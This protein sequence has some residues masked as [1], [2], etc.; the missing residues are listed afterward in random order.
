MICDVLVVYC[1]RR[2]EFSPRQRLRSILTVHTKTKAKL[3]SF[4][5]VPKIDVHGLTV[6][7][8]ASACGSTY[9]HF[10][11]SCFVDVYGIF[12][13]TTLWQSQGAYT[14]AS[15]FVVVLYLHILVC[16][17]LTQWAGPTSLVGMPFCRKNYRVLRALLLTRNVIK[18]AKAEQEHYR[19]PVC[20]PSTLATMMTM[21]PLDWPNSLY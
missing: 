11:C 14:T 9:L 10:H 18:G 12:T 7:K 13:F 2:K 17:Y 19:R 8:H 1:N 4:L 20:F 6:A 15:L 16:I 5:F 21:T 3:V